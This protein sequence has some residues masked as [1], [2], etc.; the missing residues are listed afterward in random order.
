MD[1]KNSIVLLA[2]LGLGLLFAWHKRVLIMP[3]VVALLTSLAWTFYYPYEYADNNFLLFG[4]INMYP[5]V[6]WTVSLVALYSL[7]LR[8]PKRYRPIAFTMLYFTL[9][10]AV[11]TIGYHYLNIRLTSN[12][13]SLLGLGVIHAPVSMKIFY[14]VAGPAYIL[15]TRSIAHAMEKRV[16][17]E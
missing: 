7:Y 4:R 17:E 2:L 14:V 6:L 10:G 3:F 8:L 5:L 12:Y 15:L 13:T 1:I 16:S 11:E 9:L